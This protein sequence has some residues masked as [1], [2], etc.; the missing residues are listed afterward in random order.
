MIDWNLIFACF[1][2]SCLS[3]YLFWCW[4]R[5]WYLRQRLFMIRDELWDTM[6]AEGRLDDPEHREFRDAINALIR[7]ASSLSLI[8]SLYLLLSK[9]KDLKAMGHASDQKAILKARQDV[10]FLCAKF[11]LLESIPGLLITAGLIVFG[12]WQLAFEKIQNT[13]ETL[14]DGANFRNLQEAGLQ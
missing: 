10:F 13:L 5:V 11:L 8:S 9:D 12:V 1:A 7:V 14:F 2:I 6:R 3:T 4:F